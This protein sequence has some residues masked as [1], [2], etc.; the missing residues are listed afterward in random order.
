[1]NYKTAFEHTMEAIDR[2]KL[3]G[4]NF[5]IFL[6]SLTH[7]NGK[8]ITPKTPNPEDQKH[9][10]HEIRSYIINKQFVKQHRFT[11]HA[12]EL[13]VLF[14]RH[15]MY[16]HNL[17]QIKSPI[18]LVRFYK[19]IKNH[20]QEFI[21]ACNTDHPLSVEQINILNNL[22]TAFKTTKIDIP[23][24]ILAK[25]REA[26]VNFVEQRYAATYRSLSLK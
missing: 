1:M 11:S 10:G 21:E 17:T 25:G 5:S 7:D 12:N 22:H 15:H 9:V 26:I 2:A 8:G 14:A 16:V 19:I 20:F 6:A 4:S 13:I 23:K 3:N 24:E 18:K